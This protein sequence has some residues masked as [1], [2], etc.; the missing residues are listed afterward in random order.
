[1]MFMD[2]VQQGFGSKS[3]SLAKYDRLGSFQSKYT[4]RGRRIFRRKNRG[5][6]SLA[7]DEVSAAQ[8]EHLQSV[9]EVC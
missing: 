6:S 1:M 7:A 5:K 2:K 8:V 4:I 3:R 9:L